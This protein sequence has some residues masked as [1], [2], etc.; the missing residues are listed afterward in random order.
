VSRGKKKGLR[1]EVDR[2]R[3][4]LSGLENSIALSDLKYSHIPRE[5]R[6]VTAFAAHRVC[7]L[8]DE[9]LKLCKAI[10][11]SLWAFGTVAEHGRPA[12]GA[13][14][15]VTGG[16][17]HCKVAYDILKEALDTVKGWR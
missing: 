13:G 10:E 12:D 3:G 6:L 1:A 15:R 8:K 2:L 5:Y 7:E 17:E 16:L 11:Y 9:I 14:K 4:I